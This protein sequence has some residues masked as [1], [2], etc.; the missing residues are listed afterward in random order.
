MALVVQ[1]SASPYDTDYGM[2]YVYGFDKAKNYCFS[3]SR[4]PHSE[5]IEVM[6]VDQLVS[7]VDD[8]T[9]SV[10][11]NLMT[12]TLDERRLYSWMD[13]ITMTFT[14]IDSSRDD[15]PHQ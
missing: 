6:V 8:L 3:L 12:A 13:I 1:I 15:L 4:F 10:T 11:H 7:H 14:L 9:I 5:H 2:A